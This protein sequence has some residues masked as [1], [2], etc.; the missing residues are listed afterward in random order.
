MTARASSESTQITV[1]RANSDSTRIQLWPPTCWRPQ[2]TAATGGGN[3]LSL[4]NKL[5][6]LSA[7]AAS[8]S[9][10]DN[11]YSRQYCNCTA[12]VGSRCQW[13][14]DHYYIRGNDV[15]VTDQS[16]RCLTMS[17]RHQQHQSLQQQSLQPA[18]I[19]AAKPQR[20]LLH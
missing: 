12:A 4:T 2:F 8:R 10:T 20:L 16:S 6:Q 1:S 17:S 9:F 3:L 7:P 14:T 18:P 5:Q 15:H 13:F 11:W 19:A